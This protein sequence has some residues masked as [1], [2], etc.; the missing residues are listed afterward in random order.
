MRRTS[1]RRILKAAVG[2]AAL[3]ALPLYLGTLLELIGT[4]V[5]I[6]F[7][8]SGESFTLR[9]L[10]LAGI[11]VLLAVGLNIVAGFAGLLDLGYIAFFAVG[12]YTY[13]LLS[14]PQFDIH[15]SPWLL[16]PA[17]VALTG[18][19][20]VVLG[21]PTLRLRGDYVA[22]VTLGFGEIVRLLINNL[23]GVTNG[24]G[25]I[26]AIDRPDLGFATLQTPEQ[27][28]WAIVAVTVLTIV[29]SLRLQHSRIGRAWAAIRENEEAARGLGLDTLRLKLLAFGIGA[30]IAG[31]A[32]PLFAG[33]QG[34]VSPE[35]FT[36]AESIVVLAM[37][38]LGGLGSV[39]GAAAGAVVLIILPELL[40]GLSEYRILMF[41]LALVVMMQIR[42]EGIL[43]DQV[44]KREFRLRGWPRRNRNV[45]QSSI[46]VEGEHAS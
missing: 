44:H 17:A 29:L 34:F 22:I 28:Y 13:A 32:G 25:G 15:L 11:Y 26:A 45:T 30:S 16:L 3:L 5:P 18:V 23:D 42:P 12:A 36:L 10:C 8:T 43:P 2:I 7:F 41:G 35:S 40:R 19:T 37:I 31:V 27:F 4:V 6:G 9:I 14:S 39:R 38:V 46:G 1:A 20:G 33:L 21:I 24:P